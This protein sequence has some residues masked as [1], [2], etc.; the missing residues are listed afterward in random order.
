MKNPLKK[1]NNIKI[2]EELCNII[3]KI[4]KKSHEI[5][6]HTQKNMRIQSALPWISPKKTWLQST[7][8]RRSSA[9]RSLRRS[10]KVGPRRIQGAAEGHLPGRMAAWGGAE[11]MVQRWFGSKSGGY[12]WEICFFCFFNWILSG[13]FGDFKRY[14]WDL[15]GYNRISC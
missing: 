7:D 1:R 15:M 9:V 4:M 10:C 11:C 6:S 5:P 14:E 3:K 13:F 8:P 2:H 12:L